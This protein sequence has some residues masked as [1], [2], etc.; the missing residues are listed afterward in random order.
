MT[1]KQ[2]ERIKKEKLK[3]GLRQELSNVM[4]RIQ[5]H[6]DDSTKDFP[7]NFIKSLNEIKKLLVDA[8]QLYGE[9]IKL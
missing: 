1:E 4:W 3:T 7:K 9:I 5:R 2:L 6:A 8:E